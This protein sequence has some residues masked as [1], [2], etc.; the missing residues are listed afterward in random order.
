M[1]RSGLSRTLFMLDHISIYPLPM[2]A[3]MIA[4]PQVAPSYPLDTTELDP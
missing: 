1:I 2:V 4:P 3:A